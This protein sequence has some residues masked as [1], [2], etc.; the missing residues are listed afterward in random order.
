MKKYIFLTISL[1]SVFFYTF[2]AIE[3]RLKAPLLKKGLVAF[4]IVMII[5]SIWYLID[6]KRNN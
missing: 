1:I 2:F 4:L 3:I 5:F 6:K